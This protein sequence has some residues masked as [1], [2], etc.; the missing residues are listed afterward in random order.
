MEA[1]DTGVVTPFEFVTT[2]MLLLLIVNF[3]WVMVNRVR[4]NLRRV[5]QD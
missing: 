1:G 4:R 5:K 3:V 2:I